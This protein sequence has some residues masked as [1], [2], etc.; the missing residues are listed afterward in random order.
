MSIFGNLEPRE[1][2]G[3]S[4]K[5]QPRNHDHQDAADT[6]PASAEGIAEIPLDD[7]EYP[8]VSREV[9]LEDGGAGR[10]GDRTRIAEP[11]EGTPGP[12]PRGSGFSVLLC[13]VVGIALGLLGGVAYSHFTWR[14][15]GSEASQMSELLHS[16]GTVGR[17]VEAAEVKLQDLTAKF[18][19]LSDRLTALDQRADS[20]LQSAR[21]QTQGLVAQAETRWQKDMSRRDQ[22]ADSRLS[23]VEQNQNADH[24]RLAELN[25]QL[26]KEVATLRGDLAAT[27]QGA[28]RG[29]ASL[30]DQ[31]SRNE[32]GL[33]NL[34]KQL[35]RE[36]MTFEVAKNSSTELAPGISLTILKTDPG[37]QR[38]R[39]YVSLTADGRTLWL[40]NLGAH[41]SLDIYPRDTLHPYSLIITRVDPHGVAG[42]LLLP[43]GA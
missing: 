10:G 40:E 11:P 1:G 25:N 9:P 38:F 42:Y 26:E 22:I 24:A 8:A 13:A 17:R 14:G 35:H 6:Q 28:N 7:P 19:Q 4:R 37:Y 23:H 21:R 18:G 41:K 43:A 29:L 2:N 39:G 3:S 16:L 5:G 20:T 12:P 30:H 32:D 36:R 34:G 31:V 15:R 33:Q 27:Q